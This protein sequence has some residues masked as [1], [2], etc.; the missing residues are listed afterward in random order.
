MNRSEQERS[1][2]LRAWLDEGSTQ[3]SPRVHD[4]VLREFPSITQDGAFGSWRPRMTAYAAVAV[5]AA[6]ALVLVAVAGIQLPGGFNI[7]GPVATP[8]VTESRPPESVA[9]SATD[10]G[11]TDLGVFEAV[12]GRIVF[13]V[14]A[15]LEAVDPASPASSVVIE[16]GDLGLGV[17][18]MPA[19]WSADGSKLAIS[20]EYVGDLFVM[21]ET[22][23]LDRVRVEELPEPGMVGGCCQFVDSAWLSPNGSEGLGF[24]PPG[25]QGQ[26][27]LL[28][29][30]LDDIGRSRVVEVE[31][32]RWAD[33][34]LSLHPLPVWSPDGS[35]VAY[36]WSKGGDLGTP[37]V[38]II[39]L[40][41]GVSRQLIRWAGHI[42]HL[43]WS[44]DGTQILMVAGAEVPH[45]ASLNPFVSPQ[46]TS[47]Y[48]VDIDDAEAHEIG[49]GHYVAAA[50][51][52]D[53]TRIAT[54]DYPG[55]REV[56]VIDADGSGGRQVLA[57]LRGAI[58]IGADSDLFTGVVWHP[59]PAP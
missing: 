45:G 41:T 30:D 28:V 56:V 14:G 18:A 35:Q 53:G 36:V 12:R 49:A 29:L 23:S 37:A 51:S 19:G 17:R 54:I 34:D 9:P 4:A 6:A 20:N 10:A 40:A 15:H 48:L 25:D 55:K 8:S 58:G 33:G 38:G 39:D 7:G 22:G 3:L 50:W 2:I 5:A 1:R 26:G 13:R 11:E 42:R 52:P 21:D 44:P 43:A 31:H 24:A 59:V 57:E 27:K 16:P 47:L 46:E 32:L